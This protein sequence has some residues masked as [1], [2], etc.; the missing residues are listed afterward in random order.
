[1]TVT[2]CCWICLSPGTPES[3]LCRACKCPR[4]S[5]SEC[6]AT[7]QLH[8]AGSDEERKCRFCDSRLPDW[9]A[10]LIPPTATRTE[11]ACMM[12]SC[13][14]KCHKVTVRSGPEGRAAFIAEVRKNLGLSPDREFE[15]VFHCAEPVSGHSLQLKGLDAFD[16]A[17][18]C[19]SFRDETTPTMRR[20]WRYVS[21]IVGQIV[22]RLRRLW[23]QANAR[24]M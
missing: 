20:V 6:I 2:E 21:S 10:S 17:V 7:W 4:E 15:V 19:A 9:K 13:G 18:H 12:I 5:H 14:G 16:A 3:P 22:Y 8:S 11:N 23:S 1:M 24:T